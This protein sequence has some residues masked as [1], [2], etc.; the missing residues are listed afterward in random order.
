MVLVLEIK[1]GPFAGKKID[2]SDGSTLSFGRAPGRAEFPVPHD[3]FMSGVHFVVESGP[4]GA[5]VVDKNSSNGTFLN[6]VRIQQSSLKDGDEIK[7]GQTIFV[8]RLSA[9]TSP[10]TTPENPASKV[11]ANP[12]L[13]SS[14]PRNQAPIGSGSPAPAAPVRDAGGEK[15]VPGPPVAGQRESPQRPVPPVSQASVSARRL[16]QSPVFTVGSWGFHTIPE[17]WTV[18]K[19]FGFQQTVPE[20][21]FPGSIV[22]LEEPLGAGVTLPTYVESQIATLRQ[23]LKDPQI[24]AAVPPAV[25]GAE[26]SVAFDVRQKTKDGVEVFYRR[27]YVRKGAKAGVLTLTTLA[28]NSARLLE[29]LGDLWAALAFRP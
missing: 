22:A 17:G 15:A 7:G 29:G 20:N 3:T 27:V 26:E 5:R 8:V 21:E 25:S 28:A 4:Q 6:G 16:S 23:Y 14:S 11:P 1:S 19:D 13:F 24:D 12:P 2:V 9:A 10:Q 18:Q